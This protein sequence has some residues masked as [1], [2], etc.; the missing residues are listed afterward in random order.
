MNMRT[1]HC[2]IGDHDWERESQRGRLPRNCPTHQPDTALPRFVG[3]LSGP[4]DLATRAK[5]IVRTRVAEDAPPL[6]VTVPEA[7]TVSPE[8]TVEATCGCMGR[9][10]SRRGGRYPFTT[11]QIVTACT[12]GHPAHVAAGVIER[13]LPDQM[14]VTS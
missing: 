6:M 8:A 5:D 11:V 2:E 1:L 4:P 10:L 14:K 7:V 12:T 3:M 9:L 13:F